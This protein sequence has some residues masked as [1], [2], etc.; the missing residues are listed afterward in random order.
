MQ[1]GFYEGY[2][3]TDPEPQLRLEPHSASHF[4]WPDVLAHIAWHHRMTK[5]WMENVAGKYHHDED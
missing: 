5:F 4:Y 2:E 1:P 3:A